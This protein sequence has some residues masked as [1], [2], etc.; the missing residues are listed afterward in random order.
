MA[1]RLQDISRFKAVA[2]TLQRLSRGSQAAYKWLHPSEFPAGGLGVCRGFHVPRL[3]GPSTQDELGSHSLCIHPCFTGGFLVGRPKLV[4]HQ[5][6]LSAELLNAEVSA[7][8]RLKPQLIDAQEELCASAGR[9]YNVVLG[10]KEDLC[11]Y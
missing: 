10:D 1:A 7:E 2:P 9:Q 4:N 8:A 3:L 11:P 5:P 6:Q